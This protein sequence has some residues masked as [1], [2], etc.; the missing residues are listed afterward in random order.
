M[1]EIADA[2]GVSTPALKELFRRDV[3]R[4]AF[5]KH[6]FFSDVFEAYKLDRKF[7]SLEEGTLI[8]KTTD[9]V[10]IVRGFPKIKRALTLFPTIK[11]HFDG[12]V[13]IEE[14]M[15][16]YNVRI[17]KFGEKLYAIT[18]GG[19]ICPTQTKMIR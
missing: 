15:N 11:K 8:A 13:A 4:R 7:G 9:R 6:P 10:E 18:R 5:V 3:L 16:G 19:F 2:I 14:K 12:D 17:V 1:K